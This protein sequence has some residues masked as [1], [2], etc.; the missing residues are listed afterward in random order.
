L[1]IDFTYARSPSDFCN[2]IK[3]PPPF[4]VVFNQDGT[5]EFHK[6][7][8]YN[9]SSEHQ[10][11]PTYFNFIEQ[12]ASSSCAGDGKELNVDLN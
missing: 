1:L 2:D 7:L 12:P 6:N 3:S 10:T 9:Q 5:Y 11:T 4:L 8:Q